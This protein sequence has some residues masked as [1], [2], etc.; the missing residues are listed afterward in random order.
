MIVVDASAL[1]AFLLREEG[2]RN[3]AGYFANAVA[4]DHV[5]KEAANAIWRATRTGILSDEESKKAF[6][7]LLRMVGRNLVL[8][9]E[10]DYLEGAFTLSITYGITVY[11]ALYVALALKRNLPLLTLDEKQKRVAATLGIHVK[12]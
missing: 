8:E 10:L 2:W 11:D 12:P 7:L 6:S 1:S 4:P 5:I 3:L 9:P